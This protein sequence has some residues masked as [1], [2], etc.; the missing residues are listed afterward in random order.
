MFQSAR[1]NG[2]MAALTLITALGLTAC[3]SSS[4]GGSGSGASASGGASGGDSGSSSQALQAAYKGVMET[5]PTQASK[6]KSGVNAWVVSCGQAVP[7]CATP[8]AAVQAAAQAAGWSVK[9]CDGQLNPD[10]WGSCIRQA[11]SAKA[12]V[13][14]PVGIDCAAVQQPF[15]EA[16][17]AGVQIVG[18]GGS[19]CTETG[20]Q[21]LMATERIELQDYATVKDFFTLEG[22]L[23]ADW[24]IGKTDGKGQV[25]ETIF[26]D[27]VWGPWLSAGFEKEMA[28]CSGCKVVNK[29]QLA[30]NDFVSGTATQKFSTA[31]LQA[32][33]A[34]S[35]F[36][37]VGG[38]MP[39]GF[40]Q[41]INSSG[42]K[43]Q[44]NVISGFG[45]KTNMDIIRNNGGQ[46]AIVGYPSEW[47]GWGSVDEAIRI[48]NGEKPVVE[49]DG[50]Q[51][52]DKDHALPA[53]GKDF[54][55]GV[56]WVTAYKK[57]WGVS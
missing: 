5:P 16:K 2:L 44:L 57:A 29:L 17:A 4:G 8:T 32:T 56:D 20:G 34:D 26:T 39:Q 54:T 18:A 9:V 31:L 14:F 19:D 10:G 33:T 51:V 52:V 50:L 11:V 35:V 55:G 21:S 37:S 24:I 28:T 22:K 13:V 43:A 49:G 41:A 45:D 1:R 46:N 38:W 23:A 12:T 42:R 36:V 27:P 3:G 47:G 6:P 30:N 48:L 53:S 25:L 15:T 40:A 7:S